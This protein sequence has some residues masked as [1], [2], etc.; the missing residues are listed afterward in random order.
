MPT[1]DTQLHKEIDT[2]ED[3]QN[4]ARQLV[5]DTLARHMQQAIDSTASVPAAMRALGEI[6]EDGL[7]EITTEAFKAGVGFAKDRKDTDG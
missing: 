7:A 5:A 1:L 2:L 3:L 6:V 4:R